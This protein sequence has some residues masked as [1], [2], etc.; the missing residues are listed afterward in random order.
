MHKGGGEVYSKGLFFGGGGCGGGGGGGGDDAIKPP[1]NKQI[2][3][4]QVLI[5]Q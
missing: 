1:I 5:C 2:K 4:A 3:G